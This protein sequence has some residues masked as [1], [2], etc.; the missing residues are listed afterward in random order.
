MGINM[1]W[2]KTEIIN[3]CRT[4]CEKR[5]IEIQS[6]MVSAQDAILNDTKSS[7]GDKYETSREMAQ[8]EISRLQ[9]QLQQAEID[10]D[11]INNLNIEPSEH[12]KVGSIV[13]TDQFDYFIAISIGA[14]KIGEKSIMVISKESPI[15]NLL[16][17]KKVGDEVQFNGKTLNIEGII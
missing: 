3:Y 17:S 5:I 12:V 9:T 8:Q 6:A 1:A 13:I 10:L 16:F 4:K 11:K 2:D 7:M 14:V 15:G